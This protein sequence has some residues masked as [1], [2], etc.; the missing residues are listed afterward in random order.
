MRRERG[1]EGE[2]DCVAA[3]ELG[4]GEL[5]G[6]RA[7]GVVGAGAG[8]GETAG[9]EVAVG[10][11]CSVFVVAADARG[12]EGEG[13][14]DDVRGRRACGDEVAGEDEM[15][16]GFVEGEFGEECGDLVRDWVSGGGLSKRWDV[17]L[18]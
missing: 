6:V 5:G 10:E 7:G 11:E 14:G 3:G 18:G 2:V 12:V 1:G 15:V 4:G 9:V 13:E 17:G 16:G 8:R